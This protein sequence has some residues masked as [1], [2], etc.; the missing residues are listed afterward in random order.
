MEHARIQE[1]EAKVAELTAKVERQATQAPHELE[2]KVAVL[3]AMVERLAP[4]AAQV[5]AEDRRP[6]VVVAT[7]P[8]PATEDSVASTSSRRRMLRNVALAA[9]GAVAVTVGSNVLPAAAAHEPTDIGIGLTNGAGVGGTMGTQNGQTALDYVAPGGVTTGAALLVQTGN[10]LTADISAHPSAIAAWATTP[11]HATGLYAAT[12][13][14]GEN[15]QAV[16]AFGSG[17]R[18]LG[19]L[20]LGTRAA[21]LLTP[22]GTAGPARTD[23]HAVGELIEDTTG[24]LWLNVAA[25]TP[26]TWRKIAGPATAGAFHPISQVRVYDSRSA[27]PT[28]GKLATGASRVVSIKDGRDPATGNVTATDA[29]PAGAT[30]VT[31]NITVTDTSGALGGF[32]TIMPGDATAL[33]GSSVNWFGPGQNIANSFIAKLDANRQLKVFG[34]GAPTPDTD[35]IIDITGYYL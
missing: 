24:N 11:A 7:E 1:L 10:A 33:I 21:A 20:V 13:A 29:I 9:G 18:S 31:G 2:A 15:S 34:G 14:P 26:G 19:L 35:F 23:A 4:L 25:G 17:V 16:A 27:A 30:A 3:T 8:V 6:P 32:L 12:L 22:F 5:L 28:P